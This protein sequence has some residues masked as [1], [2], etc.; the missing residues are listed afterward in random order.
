MT[1]PRQE[2]PKEQAASRVLVW[3]SGVEC[4]AGCCME[5]Q[6]INNAMR[7]IC[8]TQWCAGDGGT[9]GSSHDG[10]AVGLR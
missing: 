8:G 2:D 10:A 4:G 3:A 9:A 6:G 1:L 5:R 7:R